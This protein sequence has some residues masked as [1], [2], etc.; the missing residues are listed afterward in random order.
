MNKIIELLSENSTYIIITILAIAV[1]IVL[2]IAINFLCRNLR[3][4]K[5]LPGLLL[6]FVGII[7]LFLVINRLFDPESLDNLFIFVVG[8]SS[9]LIA[10]IF[11]LIIG[12]LTS[13]KNRYKRNRR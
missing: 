8:I 3:F 10:L 4:A 1:S 11:A 12:I 7:S 5:Y 2:T 6:V 9:G 13:D